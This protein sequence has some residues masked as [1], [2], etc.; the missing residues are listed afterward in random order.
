[1]P[2]CG[3]IC[4]FNLHLIIFLGQLR[5]DEEVFETAVAAVASTDEEVFETAV[6]AVA[7]TD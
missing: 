2:F 6:A 3:C 5:T 7:S 1:M 4:I